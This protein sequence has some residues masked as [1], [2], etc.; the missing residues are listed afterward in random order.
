M[1]AERMGC[2]RACMMAVCRSHV[3]ELDVQRG[4]ERN[5]GLTELAENMKLR[6]AHR[7]QNFRRGWLL[8]G[9]WT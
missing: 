7:P 5:E 1:S 4:I 8:P 9:R 2:L 3:E 6:L